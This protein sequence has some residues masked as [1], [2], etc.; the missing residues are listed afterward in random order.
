M[1]DVSFDIDCTLGP[2]DSYLTVPLDTCVTDCLSMI[3]KGTEC[4][5]AV[6]TG[7]RTC[8]LMF[9]LD[10][11]YCK[12]NNVHKKGYDVFFKSC[13]SGKPFFSIVIFSW[14]LVWESFIYSKA[15]LV[16]M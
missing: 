16:E 6:K 13:F 14:Y 11:D 10:P 2:F 1:L 9:Y 8:N 7:P 15:F 5:A 4:W 12:E 3:N